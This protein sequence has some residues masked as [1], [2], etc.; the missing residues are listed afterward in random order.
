MDFVRRNTHSNTDSYTQTTSTLA[1]LRQRATIPSLYV[2]GT[3]EII[4]RTQQPYNIGVARKPITTL[5]QRER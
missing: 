2:K 5:R 1:L 4:A 3:Y